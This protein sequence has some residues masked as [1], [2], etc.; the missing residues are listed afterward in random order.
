MESEVD[1]FI[2]NRDAPQSFVQVQFAADTSVGDY[3]Q[4]ALDTRA[5]YLENDG[6]LYLDRFP[7][8]HREPIQLRL[9]SAAKW[10]DVLSSD[11]WSEGFLLSE[12]AL[13]LFEQFPLGNSRQ[14]K[15]EVKGRRERRIFTYLFTANH[16]TH[17]DVDFAR[18]EFYIADMI[19]SPLRLI[20]IASADD[21]D[22][23][24]KQ[25]NRGEMEGVK[26]FSGLRFKSMHLKPNHTLQAA[27]FGLGTFGTQMLITR[28]LYDA[29]REAEVTG[30]EFKRNNKIFTD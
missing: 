26:R 2:D 17:D 13:A 1:R 25:I 27:I 22:Q 28:A 6:S 7:K 29:L 12:R 24:R 5:V 14:Y 30:L 11:L 3:P 21:Y 18:S 9:R 20:D 8:S 15:A 19:G 4:A 23:T 16:V 10:T